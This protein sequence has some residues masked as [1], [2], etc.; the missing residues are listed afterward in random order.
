MGA[1]CVFGV[2]RQACRK[3]AEK[4]VPTYCAETKRSLSPAEWRGLVMIEIDRLFEVTERQVRISPEFDA[5]QFC[6]DWIAASPGEVKLTRLMCRGEKIDKHGA[7]VVRDG[8]PV[9]TWLPYDESKAWPMPFGEVSG[10]ES[11]A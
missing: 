8:A 2:S 7:V 3:Q 11:R 9:L 4:N 6:R 10:M 1:F 5:P